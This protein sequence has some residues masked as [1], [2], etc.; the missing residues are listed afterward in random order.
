MDRLWIAAVATALLLS[1]NACASHPK[2]AAPA[3]VAPRS[4]D[5]PNSQSAA[6]AEAQRSELS[7]PPLRIIHPTQGRSD[8]MEMYGSCSP[9]PDPLCTSSAFVLECGQKE[10]HP[11]GREWLQCVCP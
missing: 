6:P 1:A 3:S 8:C 2:G 9:P 4:D 5:R 11:S 10:R 7:S